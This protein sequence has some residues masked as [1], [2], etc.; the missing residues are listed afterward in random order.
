VIA[1]DT[2]E[3]VNITELN[4]KISQI[5]ARQNELRTA[6]DKIVEDIEGKGV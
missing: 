5:V 2:R 4:A 1:E 6:I 3:V